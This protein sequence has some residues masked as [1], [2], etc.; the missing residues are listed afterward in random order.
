VQ[1]QAD[2]LGIPI[3]RPVIT[4]T[5][6]LGVAYLAGLAVGYWQS[7]E[8]IAANWKIEC[9]F[10]P[11]ISADRRE[12]LYHGWQKAIKRTAGWLKE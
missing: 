11:R 2:I 8:E 3:E 4:D 7:V 6:A 12:E 5:G 10:E 1:F 9:R